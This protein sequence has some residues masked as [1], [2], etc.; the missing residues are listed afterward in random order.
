MMENGNRNLI[1]VMLCMLRCKVLDQHTLRCSQTLDF[2]FNTKTQAKAKIRKESE[3]SGVQWKRDFLVLHSMQHWASLRSDCFF[4]LVL[5]WVFVL[6]LKSSVWLYCN[7]RWSNTLC[8]I[9]VDP[10]RSMKYTKSHSSCFCYHSAW[11]SI[12]ESFVVTLIIVLW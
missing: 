11:L 12:L 4:I 3:L 2:R 8:A 7:V 10:M 5:A 9:C 6:N 1:S